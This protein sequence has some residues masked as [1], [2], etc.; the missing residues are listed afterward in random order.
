MRRLFSHHVSWHSLRLLA[1]LATRMR[2]S[3]TPAGRAATAPPYSEAV[4]YDDF[5][6]LAGT[7]RH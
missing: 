7:A 2:R 6:F 4:V 1:P 5:I 3:T